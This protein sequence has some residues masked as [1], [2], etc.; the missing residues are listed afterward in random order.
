MV[1]FIAG[2]IVGYLGGWLHG[3]IKGMRLERP[4]VTSIEDALNKLAD[5]P[6]M[7]AK[8]KSNFAVIP[9]RRE[10]EEEE[11]EKAKYQKPD[12]WLKDHKP[13]IGS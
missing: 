13:K 7:K 3:F 10:R 4:E 9:S 12:E 11:S 1:A 6:I 5:N 2:I 8:V